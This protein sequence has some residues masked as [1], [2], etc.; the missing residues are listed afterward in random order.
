MIL[1]KTSV[2]R[3]RCC[4]RALWPKCGFQRVCQT[5]HTERALTL[6]CCTCRALRSSHVLQV[7][8]PFHDKSSGDMA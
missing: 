1:R 7:L 4:R 5:L 3:L 8:D 6:S 2:F